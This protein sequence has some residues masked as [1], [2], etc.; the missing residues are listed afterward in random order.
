MIGGE[1]ISEKNLGRGKVVRERGSDIM[2][3]IIPT[4]LELGSRQVSPFLLDRCVWTKETCHL[5]RPVLVCPHPI[6]LVTSG[7]QM[8]KGRHCHG[9]IG[10]WSP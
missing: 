3:A 2:S 1:L 7:S 10:P 5:L 4:S 9:I 6:T 8:L